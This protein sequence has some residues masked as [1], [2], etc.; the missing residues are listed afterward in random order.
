MCGIAG[1]LPPPSRPDAD[2]AAVAL[3]MCAR[4]AHRGPDSQGVWTDPDSGVTLGHRRLA[5]VDLS[6]QGR[7]PMTSASG[8]YVVVFNGEIYNHAELRQQF[9]PLPWRGHSD[10]ETLLACFDR[11]GVIASLPLLVGMFAVAVWDNHEKELT[12][13]RDRL[14]EKPLYWGALPSG[15]FVFGSELRALEAH[16]RFEGAIDRDAIADLLQYSCIGAPRSIYAHVRKLE[17]GSWMTLPLSRQTRSGRYWSLMEVAAAGRQR[18]AGPT[19]NDTDASDELERLLGQAVRGQIMADVPVGAFLSGG[20]DSSAVVAMMMRQSSTRVRTFSIGFSEPGFNEAEFAK[21]VAQHLGTQHTEHY[22]TEADAL[23][24]VEQLPDLYDEPFADPSQIPTYLVSRMAR[25]DV[26][27]A[28]S[29]DAG[30]ELFAGYNRYRLAARTWGSLQRFPLPLRRAAASAAIA[31]SPGTWDRL[32]GVPNAL[33]PPQRRIGNAGDKVHKFATRVMRAPTQLAM[34]ETLLSHWEEVEQVVPGAGARRP[35]IE[36]LAATLRAD[37]NGVDCMCLADQ[38][39]YL[40]DDILAK[41]DRA[42]MSVSLETRVPLLDHRIVEFAWGVP[43]HQKLRGKESKWLLRQV[44]YRHV[45]RALIERPKQGFGV[46]LD[47]WLRGPLRAWAEELLQESRLRAEGFL[48]ATAVRARWR[49]H[50]SGQRN[51]Q[52]ALWNVL[53]FQAWLN[54]RPGLTTPRSPSLGPRP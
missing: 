14:G 8:R 38:L 18:A 23:A 4:I 40:P 33:L 53:M 19:L 42:A 44:L 11:H 2:P 34:Y 13:A 31:I 52:Y 43:L 7:Q 29:G 15:D 41:V 3:T 46:P 49:E 1:F 39:G 17:P 21:A 37:A 48:D 27:V 51:W 28:L 36:A 12:L 50:L 6:P 32:F 25:R 16:P 9:G 54:R 45:P 22:V 35:R 5:I 10:T 47:Q 30:D 26:T 24:V 20:V